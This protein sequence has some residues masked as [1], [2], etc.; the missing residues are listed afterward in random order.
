MGGL[1]FIPV[2]IGL[3]ALPEIMHYFTQRFRD[4]HETGRMAGP[5]AGMAEF[6]RC[7]RSI[8]RG[9]LIGVG[10]GAIPKGRL[11]SACRARRPERVPGAAAEVLGGSVRR[12]PDQRSGKTSRSVLA[13]ASSRRTASLPSVPPAAG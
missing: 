10:L 2:L 9:S 4:A 1:S 13:G 8:L 6:R 12:P 7:F 3:F 11:L 5:G